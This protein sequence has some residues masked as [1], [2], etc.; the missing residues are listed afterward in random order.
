[1]Y[2]FCR[3]TNK[4]LAKNVQ[5]LKLSLH[6]VA[7]VFLV[8]VMDK[9]M[10]SYNDSKKTRRLIMVKDFADLRHSYIYTLDL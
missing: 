1:M 7:I 5:V 8:E 3:N 4:H 2:Q 10:K 6:L 9:P